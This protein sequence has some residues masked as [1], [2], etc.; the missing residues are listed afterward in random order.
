MA[1][2]HLL[3][4]C[5]LREITRPDTSNI[6]IAAEARPRDGRC[7][8]CGEPSHAVHSRTVR[9]PA[10]SPCLGCEA[11]LELAVR[12]LYCRNP[13]C[14]RQTFVER[15][16]GLIEPRAQRKDRLATT[17]GRVGVA[18]GGEAGARMLQRI[19]MPTS[20]DTV[21]RLVRRLPLPRRPAPRV[22]DVDDWARRKGQTYGTILVD[23]ER[24]RV[25]DLPLD[26]SAPTLAGW[27][28]RRRGIR[29]VARDRSTEYARGIGLGA[30][31]AV[32]V[33]N[34]KRRHQALLAR[35][36]CG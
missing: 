7:A 9:R 26:R 10:D 17:Q 34:R 1:H 4:G 27:L 20:G 22:L 2:L 35:L 13:A 25:V 8:D 30:P 18:M 19:G 6:R 23:L 24:H 21:L 33:A 32:Q 5:R 15:L 14:S 31:Q 16:P 28:R 12:R 3:P 29:T 36:R 11:R